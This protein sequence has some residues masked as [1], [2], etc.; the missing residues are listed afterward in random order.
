MVRRVHARCSSFS[1]LCAP[2]IVAALTACC[3]GTAE[4]RAPESSGASES[5]PTEG[6]GTAVAPEEPTEAAEASSEPAPPLR[7][8]RDIVSAQGVL[9]MFSFS[10]SEARQHAEEQCDK[11]AGD[12]PQK[13]AACMTK[14][15]DQFD[16]DGIAFQK[17]DQDKWWWLTIRRKGS[18]LVTLHKIEFE[19]GEETDKSI[20]IKPQGRDRGTKPMGRIPKAVVIE[21]PSESHIAIVD[22]KHGRMVYEAKLGLL[23]S[24]Q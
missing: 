3:G 14:A 24:G 16:A 15:S 5:A 6:E 10:Q 4:P 21:V 8:P 13:R 9:F 11:K 1:S 12:D 2:W 18:S 17:D 23:E 20:T 19:F 7:T 22:P